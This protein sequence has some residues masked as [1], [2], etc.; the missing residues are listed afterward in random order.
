M[1]GKVGPCSSAV[2]QQQREHHSAGVD[3]AGEKGAQEQEERL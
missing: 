3:V 1:S 2:S